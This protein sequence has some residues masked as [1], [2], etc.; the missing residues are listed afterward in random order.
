MATFKYTYDRS[1]RH[2]AINMSAHPSYGGVKT[3]QEARVA[4]ARK[5]DGEIADLKERVAREV[6]ALTQELN[7]LED[8]RN[9]IYVGELPTVSPPQSAS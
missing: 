2:V 5:I 3:E 6:A 9:S 4:C 7:I 1:A 8:L